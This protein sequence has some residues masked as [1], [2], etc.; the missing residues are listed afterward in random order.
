[1]KG[2]INILNLIA[3][4]A[5]G[6]PALRWSA[7]LVAALLVQGKAHHVADEAQPFP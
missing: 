1:M 5:P 7:A 4:V 6:P 2:A 3:K